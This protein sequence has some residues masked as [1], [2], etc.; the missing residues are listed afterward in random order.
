MPCWII[1]ENGMIVWISVCPWFVMICIMA[2]H[3]CAA[4][5]ADFGVHSVSIFI[6]RFDFAGFS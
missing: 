3:Y 5:F 2:L 1:P 6:C 4:I